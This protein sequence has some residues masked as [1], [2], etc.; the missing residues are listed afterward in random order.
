MV[1]RQAIHYWQKLADGRCIHCGKPNSRKKTLCQ[2]CADKKNAIRRKGATKT[3]MKTLGRIAYESTF[4]IKGMHSLPWKDQE[5]TIRIAY[6]RIA[7]AVEDAIFKRSQ[8]QLERS[9]MRIS[10][11]SKL[12]R[13]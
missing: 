5:E 4:K 10:R 8:K 13:S 11:C 2:V 9:R 6:E 7:R 1:T 12:T 3:T